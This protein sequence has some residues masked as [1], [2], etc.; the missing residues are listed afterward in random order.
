MQTT[1]GYSGNLATMPL[2]IVGD[3]E[4][5]ACGYNLRGLRVG[6][7]CPECGVTIP[8]LSV[9]ADD[10]LD[11]MPLRIIRIFRRAA[12]LATLCI[13][14]AGATI[15][16]IMFGTTSSVWSVLVLTLLV[17]MWLAAMW[18]LTPV[19]GVPEAATRGF[20]ERGIA[21]R[22]ARYGQVGWIVFLATFALEV[23]LSSPSRTVVLLL[24]G[25]EIAGL[26]IGGI[27]M[28]AMSILMERL[29]EWARDD[30]SARMFQW[31]QWLVPLSLILAIIGLFVPLLAP[32]FNGVA[33]ASGLLFPLGMIM[34]TG[35][36]TLSA[37]HQHEHIE[38]EIRR[39]ERR[40]DENREMDER[41]R[42]M[43][44]DSD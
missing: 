18:R 1:A 33:L 43:H 6:S 39:A 11:R 31:F 17:M 4:C 19:V 16:N 36:I 20:S 5:A 37:L 41:L 13:L 32:F 9:G 28:I 38:R 24:H 35:S 42:R 23:S 14:V 3:R 21:R 40:A 30:T 15:W 2:T 10:P 34:L 44:D 29:A 26:V 8:P 12:W 22:I 7:R 25:I 27:A